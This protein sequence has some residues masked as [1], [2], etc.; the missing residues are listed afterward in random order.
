MATGKVMTSV[1]GHSLVMVSA[2]LPLGTIVEVTVPGEAPVP[3]LTVS[4]ILNA[5]AARQPKDEMPDAETIARA[6]KP[7][8]LPRSDFATSPAVAQAATKVPH[9]NRWDGDTEG[10]SE[11]DLEAL[12]NPEPI[13]PTGR[14]ISPFEAGFDAGREPKEVKRKPGKPV[15]VF[16][17]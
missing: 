12:R 9:E 13:L 14:A 2:E 15:S 1:A 10:L 17:M 11:E 4:D 7:P 3:G 6:A 16:D 5:V 8:R